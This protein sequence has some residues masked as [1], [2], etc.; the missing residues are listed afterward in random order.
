ME[1]VIDQEGK[2]QAKNLQQVMEKYEKFDR[3]IM[4]ECDIQ[5][6][7]YL[8]LSGSIRSEGTVKCDRAFKPIKSELQLVNTQMQQLQEAEEAINRLEEQFLA[9]NSQIQE[10]LIT[11][12]SNF[13]DLTR[14]VDKVKNTMKTDFAKI[15]KNLGM[16]EGTTGGAQFEHKDML[17]KMSEEMSRMIDTRIQD[18]E[19]QIGTILTNVSELTLK[20]SERDAKRTG[21]PA[22][23]LAHLAKTAGKAESGGES[24]PPME[25]YSTEEETAH[26][27]EM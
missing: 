10:S 8:D 6:K 12:T 5:G 19:K 21:T 27:K 11:L 15:E 17:D 22:R 18:I 1:A 20:T 9:A 26:E 3:L 2:M 7:R 23:E 13:D 24:E 4:S 14:K 16:C 25:E